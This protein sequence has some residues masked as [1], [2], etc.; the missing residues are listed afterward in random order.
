MLV[1]SASYIGIMAA[2]KELLELEDVDL[3]HSVLLRILDAV[4]FWFSKENL[5]A[6]LSIV[7]HL[8]ALMKISLLD[9]VQ[10][11]NST[12]A[13]VLKPHVARLAFEMK[14]ANDLVAKV[15]A[16][17]NSL[18]VVLQALLEVFLVCLSPSYLVAQRSHL[19]AATPWRQ[20]QKRLNF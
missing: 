18:K 7:G 1:L 3:H 4:S 13:K 14:P 6:Q 16:L 15:G 9:V 10:N 5:F 17:G 8:H 12:V 11:L 2:L 19:V 20:L